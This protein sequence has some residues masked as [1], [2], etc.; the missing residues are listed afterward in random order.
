V[1]RFQVLAQLKDRGSGWH[2]YS[3]EEAHSVEKAI[4][5]AYMKRPEEVLAMVAVPERSWKPQTIRTE[6]QTRVVLGG[7]EKPQEATE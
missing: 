6:T 7:A 2:P 4:K 1:T 3:V 5:L